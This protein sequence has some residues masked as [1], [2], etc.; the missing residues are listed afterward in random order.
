MKP[1]EILVA[2][3]SGGASI[4]R[5]LE[6]D[7]ASSAGKDSRVRIAL[8]RNREARLP[9]DRVLLSTG[10]V[11]SRE[12]D[13]EAFRRRCDELASAM[14]L[15]EVWEVARDEASH[16]SLEDLAELYWGTAPD[17][18]QR[19]AC[20]LHLDRDST[21]FVADREGY[22]P[23]SR[24]AVADIHERRRREAENAQAADSLVASLASGRLPDEL[25]RP[26]AALLEHLRGYVIHGE[27]YPRSGVARGLLERLNGG[28]RDLQRLGFELLVSAGVLSPDEPL[29][30]E[31]A[32]IPRQFSAEALDEARAVDLARLL[33]QPH[34]R[35][36]SGIPTITID[37]ADT[38][39]RDDAL[40]LEAL[41][42]PAFQ[43]GIHIA[44][45]GA[46][47]T[48]G[49]ALDQEADRRMSTLYVPDGKVPMLP[50]SLSNN[51]GSLEPGEGRVALSLLVR[52]SE[53][54]EVQGWEVVPSVVRSQA[55]L[56][57]E[58][59]D[60][61]LAENGH[62]WHQ[63]LATLER[64]ALGLRRRREAAGAVVLERPEMTIKALPSG[65]VEVRVL[66]RATSS[67]QLVAEFM[68]LC[69]ALLAEFC[70][71]QDLPA[72]YRSQAVPD[73]SGIAQEAAGGLAREAAMAET[74]LRWYLVMKRLPPASL[75]TVPQPH[76]GLGVPAYIQA[77]SPLRRYPDLVMQRQ[78][79]HFLDTGRPLYS[80]EAIASVAQR[81]E[82]QLRELARI[83]DERERYWFLKYLQQS[84]LGPPGSGR[85]LFRAMVLE[86]S[87]GRT[88]LLELLDYPFRVRAELPGNH[89]PGEVVTLR[90]HGVDLWRRAAYFT[91]VRSG[92]QV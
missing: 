9:V 68:I 15:A 43:V 53:E 26:Q 75:D 42:G 20:V 29:E 80:F 8:G 32:N 16:L 12:E 49:G 52:M 1:G 77:T 59:A 28:A 74:P 17:A 11:A 85:E 88:G 67:R 31:R 18:A 39:D 87:A 22:A 3:V 33:A 2:R 60:R 79:S 10:L 47:V 56:S 64:I 54:G 23:R 71:R 13:V 14:D 90:L 50:P 82:V 62:P 36:L 6:G 24:E 37:D 51:M 55:A 57:Y 25:T 7:G 38:Q 5:C 76:G 63:A 48:H 40:S 66:R 61:A 19:A 21:Y 69:N 30:L 58:E 46:L 70:A 83:E 44:D 72:A 84:H 73:L 4:V 41:P 78:I 27:D 65:E 34:R 35:D 81:A 45:A 91:Y 92:A 89:L 86:N